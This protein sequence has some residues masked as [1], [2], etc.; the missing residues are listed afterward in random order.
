MAYEI[1]DLRI[2]A[3]HELNKIGSDGREAFLSGLLSGL[4]VQDY[5]MMKY[6]STTYNPEIAHFILDRHAQPLPDIIEEYNSASAHKMK[7]TFASFVG[8]AQRQSRFSEHYYTGL[9]MGMQ[10]VASLYS[11]FDYEDESPTQTKVRAH[12]SLACVLEWVNEALNLRSH[13]H[14]Q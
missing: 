10:Y 14:S 5:L 2:K 7:L 12:H 3:L 9:W 4:K 13:V 1:Y 6:G 11:A 8:E